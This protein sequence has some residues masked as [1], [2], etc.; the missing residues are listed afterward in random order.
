MYIKSQNFGSGRLLAHEF[1]RALNSPL[2][3]ICGHRAIIKAAEFKGNPAHCFLSLTMSAS[4]SGRAA[5]DRFPSP[6]L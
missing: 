5:F 2:P 3:A 1:L 6:E 4:I